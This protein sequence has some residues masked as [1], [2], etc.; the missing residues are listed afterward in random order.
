MWLNWWP[1]TWFITNYRYLGWHMSCKGKGKVHPTTGHKGQEGE[2]R[3]SF[4]FSLTSVL[5][6]GGWSTSRPSRFTPRKKTQNSLYRRLGGPQGQSGWVR[7]ILP[8]L[9]FDFR[10]VQPVACRYTDYATLAHDIQAATWYNFKQLG[11]T[12]SPFGK[13]SYSQG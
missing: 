3:Y 11:Q 7:K 2:Q 13:M 4:T 5:N 12:Q 9:G 6:G 1:F 8:A 10:T